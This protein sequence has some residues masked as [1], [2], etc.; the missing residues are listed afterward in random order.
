MSNDVLLPATP[1]SVTAARRFVRNAMQ[2]MPVNTCEIV[3]LLVSELATNAVVHARSEFQIRVLRAPDSVRVEVAD[4]GSGDIAPRTIA[5]SEAHGRG[6]RIVGQ[7]ADEWG[8]LSTPDSA[9]R[10]VWFRVSTA[11]E[12]AAAEA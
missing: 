7:L 5:D 10:I 1:D 3:E 11:E 4:A 6:L 2:D 12:P 8:V 9:T